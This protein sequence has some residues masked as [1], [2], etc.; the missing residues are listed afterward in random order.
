MNRVYQDSHGTFL[1]A[2]GSVFR[3]E[4]TP[5]YEHLYGKTDLV[6]VSVFVAGD[7]VKASHRYGTGLANVK[8]DAIKETWFAHGSYN[9][10][11]SEKCW[12][13]VTGSKS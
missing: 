7:A 6:T 8:K 10:E 13:P 2:D 3:P 4:V 9:G 5:R 12:T 1:K 11:P